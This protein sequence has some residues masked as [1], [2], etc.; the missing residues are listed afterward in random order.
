MDRVALVRRPVP[1]L[2]R[3]TF[4]IGASWKNDADH[5]LQ[6]VLTRFNPLAE[7]VMRDQHLEGSVQLRYEGAADT[8][9]KEAGFDQKANTRY[10]VTMTA[11][12]WLPLPE[13]VVPTI[14]GHANVVREYAT[15]QL[16]YVG[17]GN[18]PRL[19][20]EPVSGR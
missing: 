14:L 15:N 16:L 2:V 8:S 10:E 20:L 18:T 11:E 6:Q 5:A 13:L 4:T 1:F 12:A 9:E 3:Y 19:F 7:F 17:R